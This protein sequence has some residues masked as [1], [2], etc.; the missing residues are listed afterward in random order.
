MPEQNFYILVDNAESVKETADDRA[1]AVEGWSIDKDNIEMCVI[2][3]GKRGKWDVY[4]PSRQLIEM[5][6]SLS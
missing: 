3:D 2:M 4:G 6:A 1:I 5:M